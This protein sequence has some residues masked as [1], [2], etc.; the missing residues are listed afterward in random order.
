MVLP[1]FL[2]MSNDIFFLGKNILDK[3]TPVTINWFLAT[4]E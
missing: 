4:G 3:F 1:P 2:K